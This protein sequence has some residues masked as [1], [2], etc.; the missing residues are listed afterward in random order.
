MTLAIRLFTFAFGVA[1]IVGATAA[2]AH[3]HVWVTIRSTLVFA[4]DGTVSALRHAWTFDEMFSAFATQGLDKDKDGKFSREELA[5]L[6]KVNVTSLKEFNYFSAAKSDGKDVEFD[7]PIDYWLDADKDNVL[8]LH[9]TLPV[10]SKPSKSGLTV[11]IFDPIMFVDLSFAEEGKLRLEGAPT[12]CTAEA[13]KPRPPEVS[14]DKLSESFFNSLT[15]ASQ[16]G[17]QFANR[18]V[19]TCK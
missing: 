9:F 1:A 7:E 12:T 18:I 5:E 11:E 19:V 8:T 14:S 15:A 3:P 16:Y 10:K 13:K 2:D 17:S 4:G 6:A